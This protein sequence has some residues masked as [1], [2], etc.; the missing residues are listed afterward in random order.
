MPVD[1]PISS[2]K[3][4][5]LGNSESKEE[6]KQKAETAKNAKKDKINEQKAKNEQQNKKN[7]NNN[8]GGEEQHIF[9]KLDIRVGLVE[10]VWAHPDSAKL[11]CEQIDVG[12]PSVR[13]IASGL[14]QKI[15][16]DQF[17]V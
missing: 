1:T 6:R 5:K 14:Q 11:Y 16:I 9:T 3:F 15:P 2:F 8:K 17:Q 4:F 7:N 13:E 10:K 12:E